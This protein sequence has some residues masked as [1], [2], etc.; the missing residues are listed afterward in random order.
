MNT[1]KNK[2]C[3]NTFKPIDPIYGSKY[4]CSNQC[5]QRSRDHNRYHLKTARQYG[6]SVTEVIRLRNI[7]RC[8]SC[9]DPVEGKNQHID[10]CHTTGNVRGVLC[11]SCNVALG[12]VK[13]S[14]ERLENLIQYLKKNQNEI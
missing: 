14:T 13:D 6:I 7:E 8:Q 5:K 12:H 1:C 3:E 11:R 9:R 2:L 4:Y 10:H